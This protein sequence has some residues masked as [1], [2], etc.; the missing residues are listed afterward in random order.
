MKVLVGQA[1][2]LINDVL[3]AGLVPNLLS[4][5]GLGKSSIAMQIAEQNN[6]ELIDIRL[7]Q[8]DPTELSGFPKLDGTKATFVPMDLFPIEGEALPEGKVGW[9]L[10]LDELSSAAPAVVSA[11]YKLVLDRQVGQYNLHPSVYII[12]AGNLSTDKAIVNHQG[13]AMQSRLVHLE[14][15][16]DTEAWLQWA[17]NNS[18]DHRVKSFIQFKPEGLHNFD[19]NHNEHT[20]SSPRTWEFTSR[21]IKSMPSIGFDKLPLLSGTIGEGMAREFHAFTEIYRD[22]P[23]IEAIMANPT[24]ITI[25][26]EP[27]VQYALSGMVSSYLS[28]SNAAGI[29]QFLSRLTIDFQVIALRSALARDIKLKNAPAIREWI[30]RNSREL[31]Q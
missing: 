17:D 12:A 21:I 3:R 16:V 15:E 20:F 28:A 29:L 14:L 30:A 27:S 25:A 19:P 5:P 9:L 26:E 2:D 6:L 24:G 22:I 8:M 4:S 23:T 18:V 1:K 10:L 31:A 13:T 11:A 7:T